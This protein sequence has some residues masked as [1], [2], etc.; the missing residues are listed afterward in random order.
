MKKILALP[1]ALFLSLIACVGWAV[2]LIG[3]GMSVT[4][5]AIFNGCMFGMAVLTELCGD[6]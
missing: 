4:G 6:K 2:E 3:K 5:S 1:V